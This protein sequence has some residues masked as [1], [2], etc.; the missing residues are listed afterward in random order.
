MVNVPFVTHSLEFI[1]L[2]DK[3]VLVILFD[4]VLMVWRLV[5]LARV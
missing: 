1:L 3:Q 5:D 2:G 4:S